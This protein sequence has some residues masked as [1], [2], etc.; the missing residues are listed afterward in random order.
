[1]DHNVDMSQVCKELL[2]LV[3]FCMNC[4]EGID[5][6]L[7]RRTDQNI[8]LVSDLGQVNKVWS[9]IDVIYILGLTDAHHHEYF[10]VVV[11]GSVDCTQIDAFKATCCKEHHIQTF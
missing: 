10:W 2:F 4:V 6:K 3:N 9:F 7:P 8:S 5:V 11:F 1:M